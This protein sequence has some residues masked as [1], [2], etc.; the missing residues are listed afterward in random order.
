MA[1]IAS[2]AMMAGCSQA[3]D[4]ADTNG[5][6]PRAISFSTAD[7]AVETTRSG[8]SV[9][10]QTLGFTEIKVYGYKTLGGAIQNVMPG[11]TL[12]YTDNSAN[13]STTNTTGWEY[14]GLGDTYKDYLGQPQ[15]I[16]YWDGNSTDYRFFA[17]LP[18]NKT[19]LKY[20][21]DEITSSTTMSTSGKF[22][23]EFDGL[24]YMTRTSDGTYYDRNGK[25]VAETEIP[26]YGI[27][28]QGDPSKNNDK[29]VEL[30]FVKPYSLVRLVF[31]RPD[32]TSTTTLGKEG[33]TTS[34]TTFGP[35]NGS[36][37]TGDGKV[38]VSW[39]MTGSRE[40]ATA[41]AGTTTLPTMTLNPVTITN[42]NER[43]Q[44]WPEY[45]MIPTTSTPLDFKCTVQIYSVNNKQ[46]VFDQ[47]TAIV[48]SQY[49]QWKPGY[50]YT[51]VFKVTKTNELEF[52]HVLEVYTK[53]QAGYADETT[54]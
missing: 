16:K 24:E 23:M 48:P 54:W 50:Q 5:L 46:D 44:A 20:D 51:Y 53:W 1:I 39:G 52:S 25:E 36:T 27:L 13:S 28:W 40:T 21:G 49:M 30:A 47:R 14:V 19:T 10:L 3:D 18:N 8:T 9:G 4:S 7:G 34:Y 29:P 32:G 35:N 37:L 11:Y 2:A 45:L 22:S 12:K 42:Q 33:A 41:T 15:E 17:V 26:M 38:D 31:M 6:A 43:Y